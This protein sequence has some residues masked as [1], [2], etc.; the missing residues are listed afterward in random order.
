M[1]WLTWAFQWLVWLL[2]G[3]GVLYIVIKI[4]ELSALLYD[5]MRMMAGDE[6][7]IRKYQ[8]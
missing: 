7:V 3:A 2:M 1:D 4:I 5:L 6:E 8:R